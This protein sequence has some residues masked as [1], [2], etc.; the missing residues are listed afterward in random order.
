MNEQPLKRCSVCG[1]MLPA[2]AEYFTRDRSN[3]DG[4]R[5]QC[6][7][8]YRAK[9]RRWYEEDAE[10]YHSYARKYYA[11]SPEKVKKRVREWERT[12]LGKARHREYRQK[13]AP[14]L[15]AYF[16]EHY[17]KNRDARIRQAS[18]W[19]RQNPERRR[20]ILQRREARKH[21]LPDAMTGQDWQYA[22]AYFSHRCAVCGRP[23]G[24]WH[25]LAADHWIPLS[26]PRCP[27]TVPTNIVPLCHG[28]G[29]C[30]N[31]KNDRDPEEWLVEK[32][33]KRRAHQILSRIQAY[34]ASLKS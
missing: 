23:I 6:K 13:N 20:V 16:R 14:K 25:T 8:C 19:I 34:F 11:Q 4:L 5:T 2:T 31:S 26:N 24:L 1:A 3:K 18:D 33:G 9:Q 21:S 15:S 30:N 10:R 22:L 28:Q 27:G 29:G 12:D 32:F 7:P 17:R